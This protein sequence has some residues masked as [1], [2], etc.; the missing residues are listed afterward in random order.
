MGNALVVFTGG[1]LFCQQPQSLPDAD[2]RSAGDAELRRICKKILLSWR[3]LP[4][5]L[6]YFCVF[7]SVQVRLRKKGRGE[8]RSRALGGGDG[9]ALLITSD[10]QLGQNLLPLVLDSMPGMQK[11]EYTVP[12]F[13][14]DLI[15]FSL[16]GRPSG[17]ES[18][19]TPQVAPRYLP[20]PPGT[21]T[22][23][24]EQHGPNPGLNSPAW[25]QR[26][27]K[28]VGKAATPIP[29]DRSH[30]S[31]DMTAKQPQPSS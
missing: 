27:R 20:P 15:D 4:H 8:D 5:V 18:Q 26:E 24:G 10:G 19:K 14:Y 9:L 29:R 22:S 13:H 3:I 30:E 2:S 11:T 1:L 21:A 28:K 12:H 6:L 16:H 23:A 17:R 31:T 7:L 25:L